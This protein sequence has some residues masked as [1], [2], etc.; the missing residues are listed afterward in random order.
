MSAMTALFIP[1]GGGPYFFMDWA[2]SGCL[3]PD[4]GV[5]ERHTVN[6]WE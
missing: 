1:H 4:G 3:G 2:S 6:Y 5:F